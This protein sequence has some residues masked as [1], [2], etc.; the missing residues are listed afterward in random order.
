M[1][2]KLVFDRGHRSL[3]CLNQATHNNLIYKKARTKNKK[4]MG[5]YH[6]G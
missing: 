6:L 4:A 2:K 1:F 3:E 5:K